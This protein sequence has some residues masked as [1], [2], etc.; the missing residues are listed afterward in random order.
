LLE[1]LGLA[2]PRAIPPWA[3]RAEKSAIA[4]LAVHVIGCAEQ[5]DAVALGLVEREARELACHAV[6]LARRL[7]P[8][9]EPIPV[10]FHGGVLATP[11]YAGVVSAAMEEFEHHF[12]A[13]EGI[14]DAVVGAVGRARR[15]L[16]ELVEA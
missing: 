15:M 8:W 6:A 3:G 9:T 16:G 2:K 13:R 1:E 14:A 4:A 5:G 7:E 11:F 12:V 10:V